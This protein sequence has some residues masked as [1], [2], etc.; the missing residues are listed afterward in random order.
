MR[1]ETS[2]QFI[3]GVFL[4]YEMNNLIQKKY[5]EIDLEVSL[6]RSMDFS[7]QT[8]FISNL[9][10]L[11]FGNIDIHIWIFLLTKLHF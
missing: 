6:V 11:V 9:L 3:I 2:I 5:Q 8:M 4:M 1:S 10:V 7:L